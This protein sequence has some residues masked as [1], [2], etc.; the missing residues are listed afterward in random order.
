MAY[1][2]LTQESSTVFNAIKEGLQKIKL[3]Q[4]KTF[5]KIIQNEYQGIF[6]YKPALIEIIYD[7]KE[8]KAAYLK[9]ALNIELLY[10]D[11][12]LYIRPPAQ[13]YDPAYITKNEERKQLLQHYLEKQGFRDFDEETLKQIAEDSQAANAFTAI[14]QFETDPLNNEGGAI[15][16]ELSPD[17]MTCRALI[18]HQGTITP[19]SVY[20]VLKAKQCIK[21]VFRKAILN[22]LNK[23]LTGFFEIARGKS[24][25]EPKPAELEFFF[26]TD[27][28]KIFA[29]MSQALKTDTRSVKKINIAERNQLLIRIGKIIAGVDGYQV[30]GTILKTADTDSVKSSIQLGPNVTLS[31]DGKEIYAAQSGHIVWKKQEQSINIEAIYTVEGDVDFNEGNIVGFVGKVLIMG[32]VRPKFSVTAEG[33]I[34][35]RGSVEDAVVESMNGNV[36]VGGSIVHTKEGYILSKHTV[37]GVIATNA[38]IRA[39]DIILE[40]E[41]MNSKLEADESITVMGNPGAIIGGIVKAKSIIRSNIIGSESWADTK[42]HVGNVHEM[43]KRANIINN[44]VSEITKELEENRGIVKLLQKRQQ[45]STLSQSQQEQLQLL[46]EKATELEEDIEMYQEEIVQMQKQIEERK[47]AKLEILKKIYP[48]V[49]IHIYDAYYQTESEEPTTGFAC[50][51][52]LINRY[53]L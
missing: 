26:E 2:K 49:D 43:R 8:S 47:K 11:N 24:P 52:G 45:V 9:E 36:F 50:R 16:L 21:G 40:K 14:K 44:K 13:F 38:N 29:E 37:H 19:E 30:D 32:D 7:E 1:C 4:D 15:F 25:I 17:K 3:T 34:E 53:P 35:I 6:G 23:K 42:V 12:K 39:K 48:K 28:N 46:A 31:D 41:V 18:F 27:E 22:V 5:I 51:S 10:E 20:E 33:D